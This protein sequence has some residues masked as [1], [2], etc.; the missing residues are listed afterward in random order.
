MPGGSAPL[1]GPL[2]QALLAAAAAGAALWW[3]SGVR[4]GGMD[5]H[6]LPN[7]LEAALPPHHRSTTTWWHGRFDNPWP[8]WEERSFGDVL[9]WN[10]HRRE[11]AVLPPEGPPGCCEA[12]AWCRR[13]FP[14]RR[15]PLR[16]PTSSLCLPCACTRLPPAA[17]RGSPQMAT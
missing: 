15:Q 9:R 10:K 6:K 4:S 12:G 17:G 5:S 8:T 16:L 7:V 1:L 11:C 3:A 13:A 14:S 2:S